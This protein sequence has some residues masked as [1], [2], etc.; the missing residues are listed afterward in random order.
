MTKARTTA[1]LSRAGA[2]DEGGSSVRARLSALA[3]LHTRDAFLTVT[4]RLLNST[5]DRVVGR[6]DCDDAADPGATLTRKI[7]KQHAN[8]RVDRML[9]GRLK[10]PLPLKSGNI[11]WLWSITRNT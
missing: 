3:P 2:F 10:R 5:P 9:P 7:K 11:R 6:H 4:K 8:R 1:P